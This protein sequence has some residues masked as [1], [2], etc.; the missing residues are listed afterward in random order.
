[1]RIIKKFAKLCA[2]RRY[3][4]ASGGVAAALGM[5]SFS[6]P[7]WAEDSTYRPLARHESPAPNFDL[8]PVWGAQ[9][10]PR[11]A[12]TASFPEN[13]TTSPTKL[14]VEGFSLRRSSPKTTALTGPNGGT[15]F[16]PLTSSDLDIGGKWSHGLKATL[17]ADLWDRPFEFSAFFTAPFK[18]QLLATGL[19]TGTNNASIRTNAIYAND[20]G[21]DISNYTNSQNIAQMFVSQSSEL[22]GAEANAKSSF[23]IPGLL[24]GARALYFGEDL[25]TV[26]QKISPVTG[27]DAVTVQTRNYLF[28]PQIGFEGMIDIGGGVKVGG[29][30]KA[31]LFANFVERERSFLSRNQTRTR[32]QQNSLGGTKFSQAVEVN[33]RIEIP[34]AKGITFTAGGTLLWLNNV[35]T[36]FPYYATVTDIQDRNIRAKDHALFYGVQAGLTFNLD[37]V[38]SFSPP[39]MHKP[40][41]EQKIL[42]NGGATPVPITIYGEI[43]RMALNWN[44]G[45]RN[46]TR[47]VDN[48]SAPSIFGVRTEAELTRGWTTGVDF[49][50]G[51]YQARS[52]AVSQ[53]LPGGETNFTPELRYLDLWLR[54]NR[55]GKLTIGHTATATDNAI[56][57]DLSGTNG[58]VSANIA[59]IGSDLMLRAGDDLDLGSGSLITRTSIGDFV[60]GATL[61]TLRR[62]VARYETPLFKGFELSFAGRNQ[63]WDTALRYRADSANWRFRAA[64]GYLRDTDPGT[65]EA[66]GGRRDRREWKGGASLL[67]TPTGLFATVAF[68]DRQFRGNDPSNQATF[69][70]NRVDPFGDVIPG[71]HR[72]DLRFGY[73]K[74]GLRKQFTALG[75]TKFYAEAAIAKNGITG[76]REAGPAEVTSSQLNMLGAG[77]MQDIDAYNMQ[78]YLG[79]RHYGFDVQGVR[80]SSQPSGEIASPAPIKDIDL[81]YSGIRV[82]F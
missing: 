74:T 13:K 55:Y 40:Y 18:S 48:T 79:Y 7:A 42:E 3:V 11:P 51:M 66:V 47:V 10:T 61:D 73:L 68:V 45:V 15:P 25:N 80:D 32:A 39:A 53:T 19:S 26:T 82:K 44:D 38:A 35:S 76:L 24:I 5:T 31:G 23:G 41:L 57:T 8:P 77:V 37:T 81:V 6:L 12:G 71:T 52:V 33:P 27:I 16:T 14:R 69:G 59:L 63:F 34:L 36:A 58:A 56:L 46:T 21:G 65:R 78:V 54:S 75:D 1:M 67:H 64:I 2:N 17:D 9:V 62:D 20:P 70:E 60:G 30:V 22:F 72:P 29:S 28:G 50:A 49:E 4:L 43:N